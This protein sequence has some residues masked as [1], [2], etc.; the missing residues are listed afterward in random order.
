MRT[1]GIVESG[2]LGFDAVGWAIEDAGLDTNLRHE[3]ATDVSC[4][5]ARVARARVRESR[6]VHGLGQ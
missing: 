2:V 4:E 5:G 6:V 1:I 3:M